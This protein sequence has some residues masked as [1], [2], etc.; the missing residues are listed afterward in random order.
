[1]SNVLLTHLFMSSSVLLHRPDP[2]SS[3]GFE[4]WEDPARARE[5]APAMTHHRDRVVCLVVSLCEDYICGFLCED[6]VLLCDL[7][8]IV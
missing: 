5:V 6:Y 2:T 7:C 8:L 4:T 3:T 1:M